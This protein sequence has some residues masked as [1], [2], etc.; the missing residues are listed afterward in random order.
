ML[1]AMIKVKPIPISNKGSNS[2]FFVSTCFHEISSPS[3]KS[4][5]ISINVEFNSTKKIDSIVL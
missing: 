4:F 3:S 1:N 5:S 2:K